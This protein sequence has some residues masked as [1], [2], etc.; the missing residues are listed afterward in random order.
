MRGVWRLYRKR[1]LPVLK[2][3]P[4][5]F[6]GKARRE[7]VPLSRVCGRTFLPKHWSPKSDA[8]GI[9]RLREE[10]AAIEELAQIR[11]TI[12]W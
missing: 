10:L 8:D 5:A 9:V 3:R 2:S 4:Y 11:Y 12:V 7:S 1:R 6:G